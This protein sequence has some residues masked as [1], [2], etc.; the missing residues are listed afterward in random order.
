MTNPPLSSEPGSRPARRFFTR[1]LPMLSPLAI[2]PLAGAGGSGTSSLGLF[3][4]HG[5][6]G[7][8][9]ANL[10]APRRIG[11]E[12]QGDTVF[13][14]AAGKGQELRPTGGSFRIKLH[15]PFY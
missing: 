8:V 12:K 2:L 10:A 5:D 13:M 9:Q 11:L 3:E 1:L 7:E 4:N 15:A 14:S 6:I